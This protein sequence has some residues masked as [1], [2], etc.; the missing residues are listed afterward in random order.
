MSLRVFS[1]L[2]GLA[3]RLSADQRGAVLIYVTLLLPVLVGFSLLAVD[4]S[5]LFNLSTHL[6]KGA[7]A[8]ALAGAAELDRKPDAIT[9]ADAA[10]ANMVAN[11]HKF[12]NAGTVNVAVASKRYLSALPS[13]DANALASA[14]VTTDPEQAAFVEV[15][16]TTQTLT[17]LMPASF[18]GGSNTAT[19]AAR[20]VAGH[21]TCARII[22]MYICNPYEGTSNTIYDVIA[23][24]AL[25]RQQ[26][27][28]QLGNGGGSSQFYPGNYGWLD[29]PYYGN[30]ANGLRDALAMSSP[31]VCFLQNGVSQKTGNIE[32]AND[33]INVRFDIWNGPYNNEKNNPQYQ[34]ARNVRK[35]YLPKGKSACNVT[36]TLP[37]TNKLG[38]DGDV[39]AGSNPSGTFPNAGGRMGTGTWDFDSYWANNY[40]GTP[41]NGWSNSSL[42]T[43]YE[44]YSYE[45]SANMM[46]NAAVGGSAVGEKGTPACYAGAP[47]PDP[48]RRM[49]YA[50]II[51]C[52]ELDVRGNSGGPLPVLAFG[53]F[54][55]TEPIANPPDPDAGTIYSELV[56]LIE[57]GNVA[58]NLVREIVQLY[59]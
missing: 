21:N 8:L 22:P 28:M 46:G 49:V 18:L 45:L 3:K 51:N 37:N 16:V 36:E 54:F 17:T 15:T 41:P 55:L 56:E 59:R 13:S 58:S 48:D 5:R 50:A 27:K 11:Q 4:A 33:A 34:P 32:S 7:D 1:R 14:T 57:P 38:R 23:N 26:I 44:V 39:P 9:R 43:R 53:K 19:S 10:I 42:P 35:G 30:G 12:S 31:D 20:A 47:S 29:T 52:L 6:Q 2:N 40:G 24:P 25:R